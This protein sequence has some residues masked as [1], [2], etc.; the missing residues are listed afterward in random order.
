MMW[1]NCDWKSS[2]IHTGSFVLFIISAK[3]SPKIVRI[4]LLLGK[5]L[6]TIDIMGF[7]T[8]SIYML[9]LFQFVSFLLYIFLFTCLFLDFDFSYW[10]LYLSLSNIF[11]TI[12]RE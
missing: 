4:K 7:I 9:F 3:I 12:S 8:K 5:V 10:S 6:Q 11:H 1:L 2:D